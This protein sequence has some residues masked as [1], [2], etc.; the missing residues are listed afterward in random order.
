MQLSQVAG[1]TAAERA[2]TIFSRAMTSQVRWLSEPSPDAEELGE[3]AVVAGPPSDLLLHL[4][5]RLPGAVADGRVSEDGDPLA[6]QLLRA[7]L[8]MA[9]D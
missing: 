2:R 6:R 9:T 5:G 3:D 7:R 1:P 4:W 8:T